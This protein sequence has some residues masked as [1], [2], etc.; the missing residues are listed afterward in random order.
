MPFQ[1]SSSATEVFYVSLQSALLKGYKIKV[2]ALDPQ[3]GQQTRQQ[4]L[5][6]ESEVTSPDSV[7]FVGANA[8]SPL[9]IWADKSFKTLKVNVIGSKQVNTVA[10]DSPSGEEIRKVNVHAPTGQDTPSHFLVHYE[11]DT[12]SWVEVYHANLE[13]STVFKAY[14][15]PHL[16][17]S[18][19]VA[20]S[21]RAANVF[22]THATESEISVVSSTSQEVLGKWPLAEGNLKGAKHAAA[23]VVT[24]GDSASVR[25]A[26]V[27]DSGDWHLIQNGKTEW[28]RHESLA[29][30]VAAAWAE[31]SQHEDIAHELEMES[32]E[33]VLAA[34]IHRVK[35]HLKDLERLPAWL[36]ELPKRV[37]SSIFSAEIT[38]LDNFGVRKLVLVA[39]ERGRVAALD[40]GRRGA[41]TWNVKVADVESW[42]VKAIVALSNIAS[43]YTGDGSVVN[44]NVTTGEVVSRKTLDSKIKSIATIPGDTAPAIIGIREDGSPLESVGYLVTLSNDGRV[45]G[46]AAGNTQSPLWQ[47]VPPSGDTVLRATSRPAHDPVASIGKVLGDRSVL[48]KYLNPNLVLVTTTSDSTA[49]FYLLDGI[50]GAVLYSTTHRGVDTSQPITSAMAE[51]WFAYSLYADETPDSPAKG[52]QLVISE[53][54]ESPIPNDRGPLGSATNYSTLSSSPNGLARPHVLTQSFL[55]P[56]PISHMAVT[57]TRQGITIRQLICALPTLNSLIGIPRP[58]LDPRRPVGRDP[59]TAE[60]EEGLTKYAPFL[61]FDGKWF[62]SHTRDLAR[63]RAVIAAPTLLESTGLVFAFGGG[64]VFGSRVAPSQAFDILGKGFSKFQLLVTVIALLVGVVILA[65]MVRFFLSLIDISH[66]FFMELLMLTFSGCSRLDGNKSIYSGSDN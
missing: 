27:S 28:T 31:P 16:G 42:D 30:I 56:E 17:G 43:I 26:F 6:S 59:T 29:G 44:L 35:R 39:T 63:V 32:H 19:V 18:S 55:I 13:S 12:G 40:T 34:Y 47:F 3:T 23:D 65:P 25:L 62:L 51:N 48:Y 53:L 41:V 5:S 4:I 54:Y 61:E 38:N 37:A 7:L 22:F 45:L 11:T 46:W 10:I 52:F 2:T 15:L 66:I 1:V 20:V 8:A 50:S 58:V 36:Q 57:Q 9:I 49:S 60:R 24:R 14:Q 21:Q 64:D 33:N